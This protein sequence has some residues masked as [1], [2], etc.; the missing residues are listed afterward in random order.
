MG[1]FRFP[2]RA[3]LEANVASTAERL[4]QIRSQK[5]TDET[6]LVEKTAALG[7][8]GRKE[9]VALE[10]DVRK[11]TKAVELAP[12]REAHHEVEI[13]RLEA[14]LALHDA[15]HAAC[16]Q[17]KPVTWDD[18][19]DQITDD[20]MV[21]QHEVTT[22]LLL[23]LGVEVT[24][25]IVD[26]AL[27]TSS[28]SAR[29]G[30]GHGSIVKPN[31]AT[32]TSRLHEEARAAGLDVTKPCVFIQ[33]IINEFV[34]TPI[35]TYP[36]TRFPGTLSGEWVSAGAVLIDPLGAHPEALLQVLVVL[37]SIDGA[38]IRIM[39]DGQEVASG[40]LVSTE[41]PELRESFVPVLVKGPAGF[42]VELRGQGTVDPDLVT[43]AVVTQSIQRRV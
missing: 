35:S 15:A 21:A 1:E 40:A 12:V 36:L 3:D 33:E 37:N 14:H 38:E 2:T 11:L 17:L 7:R 43:L 22:H 24:Q 39:R 8:A 10:E 16:C 28:E 34:Y 32:G 19:P 6:E 18:M 27:R 9:R 25:E 41:G 29:A 30:W 5:R 42:R 31:P 20:P 26:E 23:P 4:G 13:T